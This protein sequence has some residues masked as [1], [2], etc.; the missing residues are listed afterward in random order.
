MNFVSTSSILLRRVLR[1]DELVVRRGFRRS[2]G[3]SQTPVSSFVCAA[4]CNMNSFYL[5][6]VEPR[7]IKHAYIEVPVLSK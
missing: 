7:Y 4:N 1:T 6:T 2:Q 5:I 3:V